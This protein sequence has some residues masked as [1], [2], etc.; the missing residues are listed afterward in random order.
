MPRSRP[1]FRYVEY[2]V[3]GDHALAFHLAPGIT[4]VAHARSRTMVGVC[5]R[6]LS[7]W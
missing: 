2:V 5:E 7:A 4:S 3:V 1:A 6:R